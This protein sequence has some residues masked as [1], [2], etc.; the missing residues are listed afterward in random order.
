M[1]KLVFQITASEWN[2]LDS[3]PLNWLVCCNKTQNCLGKQEVSKL[4]GINV[5]LNV[6]QK[7]LVELKGTGELFH[8]L[9]DALNELVNNWR[10]FFWITI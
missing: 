4:A 9:P 1:E 8:Q 2:S 7:P 3:S 5:M 6:N 10:D